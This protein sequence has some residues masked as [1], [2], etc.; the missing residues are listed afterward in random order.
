MTVDAIT[1]R[2]PHI[3]ETISTIQ[4]QLFQ[5]VVRYCNDNG[6]EIDVQTLTKNIAFTQKEINEFIDIK[7]K[8]VSFKLPI[9][10]PTLTNKDDGNLTK[11]G[12]TPKS[13]GMKIGAAAKKPA[14][15]KIKGATK[16]PA[17]LKIKGATKKPAGLKINGAAKKSAGLKI[18]GAAKKP[19]GLKIEGATKKPAGLKIDGATKKPAGLKID[20][21]AKKPAGLKIDG[22][23]KKPAGLKIEAAAKK[24]AGLKIEA[25][26]KKPT[27]LKIEAA[28]KKPTGLKIEAATKK[29]T[30][31]KIDAANKKSVGLKIDGATKKPAGLKIDGATKKPAGLKIDGATKKPASLELEGDKIGIQN[32]EN[33][34]NTLR[35]I[36]NSDVVN[37]VGN[38]V[39]NEVGNEVVNEADNELGNEVDNEVVNEADNELGNEAENEVGNEAENEVGNEADHEVVNEATVKSNDFQKFYSECTDAGLEVTEHTYNPIGSSEP[40]TGPV[41]H[42][43]SD[44]KVTSVVS[45]PTIVI[46]DNLGYIV[47]PKESCEPKSVIYEVDP[48]NTFEISDVSSEIE[49]DCISWMYDSKEYILDEVTSNVYLHDQDTDLDMFVGKR[50]GKPGNYSIDE[51]ASEE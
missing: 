32:S 3:A 42:T 39:V 7:S 22:A 2:N 31:L 18:D 51:N 19:A 6:F 44:T 37:E 4:T 8:S 16:K 50:I 40:W 9:T 45:V 36:D 49:V 13:N 38:E 33:Q 1:K 35:P 46:D 24:P 11:L 29:P 12:V 17:G 23:T 48:E 15:L 34:P 41:V 26:T 14:G 5:R 21:A 43:D 25:A 47:R 20:G 10:S 28:T 27:G 30:G